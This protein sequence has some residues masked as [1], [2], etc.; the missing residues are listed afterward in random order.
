MSKVNFEV[1]GIN[2]LGK[3]ASFHK[4]WFC[5]LVMFV[6][7]SGCIL[8]YVGAALSSLC[9][10]KKKSLEDE[11][12][13]YDQRQD[14][15][16]LKALIDNHPNYSQYSYVE[17]DDFEA[18]QTRS[19]CGKALDMLMI[20]IP[21]AFD[22]IATVLMSI[23]LL[24]VTV[25]IYQMM[26]GAELIF[27]AIFSV[28][29]LGKKLCK[30]HYVGISLSLVGISTVGV[31]SVLA[32]DQ[33]N[34]GTKE[35][36]VMGILLIILSQ[37]IQ[38]GQI[39]F[40]EHF[41]RNMDFMKPT[42]VVGLEGIYGV[43]LQTL[44]VLPIAQKLPGDDVGGRLENTVDTLHMITA[45]KDHVILLSLSVTAVIMLFYNVLGMQVT[46]HLGA[47]F[48][49]ILETTRT[50]LA[51]IVGLILYYS[52]VKLYGDPIGEAWTNYSYLQAAGFAVLVIGT[53][54]YA[55]GDELSYA[56]NQEGE[57]D[58]GEESIY[59]TQ[60]I[61]IGAGAIDSARLLV[62]SPNAAAAG[63][64]G[65][66]TASLSVTPSRL[67]AYYDFS[68]GSLSRSYL[69]S[70]FSRR[71]SLKDSSLGNT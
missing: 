39:C 28:A 2:T 34:T 15:E 5:V 69:K 13:A 9:Q 8:L 65:N 55:K 44:I 60:A 54:V 64:V 22:L 63:S 32:P 43:L 1:K 62:T 57:G 70:S 50:L 52:D 25:S 7:M 16:Y 40:E 53:F 26:R 48:R 58:E 37:A 11:T 42:L 41:M 45:S 49:S 10:R 20:V 38:A 67:N 35:Q 3:L 47:L 46:S 71:N 66:R 59:A 24:Y 21:T 31:A 4:P 29:F 14:N 56:M 27:A 19:K 30:L 23:G 51:W 12:R 36:Q 68:A 6:G 18:G 61:T 33:N 17:D